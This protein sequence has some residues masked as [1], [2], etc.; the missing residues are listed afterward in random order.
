MSRG[1]IFKQFHKSGKKGGSAETP[2]VPSAAPVQST[3][4][5]TDRYRTP[6]PSP[7]GGLR[8][9]APCWPCWRQVSPSRRSPETLT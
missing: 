2:V 6:T 1:M 3:I 7:I 9:R 4:H 8:R 5:N